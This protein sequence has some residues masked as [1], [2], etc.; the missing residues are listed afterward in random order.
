HPQTMRH[1]LVIRASATALFAVCGWLAYTQN[2]PAPSLVTERIKDDLFV[3]RVNPGVGGGDVAVYLTD[4]GVILVDDMFDRNYDEIM[5]KVKSLTD[6]P[7]RYVLNTHQHDDHAGGNAKML[8][9][10]DVIAHGNVRTNMER[11]KEPGLPRVTFSKE[12]EV[13]LGGK[14]VRAY[15]FGR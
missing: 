12:I 3:I 8:P 10:A 13:H 14:E 15:H 7:V 6:K 5:A 4:E 1:P 2:P 11:L 9:H